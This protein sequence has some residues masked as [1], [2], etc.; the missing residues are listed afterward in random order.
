M[1]YIANA[2]PSANIFFLC[3]HV[4]FSRCSQIYF[5]L[6]EY[7]TSRTYYLRTLLNALANLKSENF[8][9]EWHYMG[10]IYSIWDQFIACLPCLQL[11]FL[12]NCNASC[13]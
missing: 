12:F 8:F 5:L 7:V 11:Y 2:L 10:P 13:K 6:L 1:K 3:Y 9:R 4:Y